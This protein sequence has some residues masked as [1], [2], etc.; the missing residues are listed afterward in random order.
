[1]VTVCVE[2]S[3]PSSNDVELKSV[4]V[5]SLMQVSVG[6]VWIIVSLFSIGRASRDVFV[7][8]GMFVHV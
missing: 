1:M 6:C 3:V 5:V 7:F 4:S 2:K 8:S